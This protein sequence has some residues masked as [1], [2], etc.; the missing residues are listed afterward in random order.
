M[1]KAER[2]YTP[3]SQ[4]SPVLNPN[5]VEAK[6]PGHGRILTIMV[7]DVSA[8]MKMGGRDDSGFTI[9]RTNLDEKLWIHFSC[10][11][12]SGFRHRSK[13]INIQRGPCPTLTI[14]SGSPGG[15]ACRAYSRAEFAI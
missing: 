7:C 11:A 5:E 13:Y 2:N 4:K 9:L 6:M 15:S 1:L 3:A 10:G 14:Y 12:M 8:A